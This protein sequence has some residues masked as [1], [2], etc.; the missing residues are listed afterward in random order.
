[1]LYFYSV[2]PQ[3]GL[4][5]VRLQTWFPL[6]VQVYVNGHSW[7]AQQLTRRRIGFVQHD[8]AFTEL[9]DIQAAQRQAD[10]FAH[11]DWP[12]LLTRLVRRINPLMKQPWFQGLSYYWVTDQAELS[13]DV[14]FAS[15][16]KLAEIFPTLLDVAARFTPMDILTYLGRRLHHRFDGEVMTH[17]KTDRIPGARIKHRMKNNWLKMYD[18]FGQIL[19]V[20][21]VINNPREFPVPRRC[22][23]H[24]LEIM[25]YAPMGKGVSNLPHYQHVASAANR[26]YLDALAAVDVPRV[27]GK[28]LRPLTAR[29]VVAGRSYAGFSPL[30]AEDVRLFKAVLDGDHCLRGFRNADIRERLHS[31]TTDPN[32]QRRQATALGRKLKRLHVRRLLARIPRTRRWRV[33]QLGQSLLQRS[34]HL[35]DHGIPTTF[36]HAA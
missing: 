6:T 13:T 18:K 28:D 5:Y 23:H 25:T 36:A 11:L 34:I 3:L 31:P 8:N 27:A 4:I 22:V 15:R 35:H 17:V 19:R 12:H 24:G 30:E 21:T 2:D 26:R 20:E 10:R 1:V 14:I 9:D 7:L 29:K 32:A 33:T 16:S